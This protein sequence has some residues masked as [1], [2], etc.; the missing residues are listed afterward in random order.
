[1]PP[2]LSVPWS[3]PGATARGPSAWLPDLVHKVAGLV[4]PS[5]D[6]PCLSPLPVLKIPPE[7]VLYVCI[8]LSGLQ[9]TFRGWCEVEKKRLTCERFANWKV[10]T[11]MK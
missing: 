5:L 2:K 10:N 8:E 11:S 9:S 3:P 7:R 1:M 6:H 4:L